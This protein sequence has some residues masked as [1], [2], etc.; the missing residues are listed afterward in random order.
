VEEGA[1]RRSMRPC[2]RNS[3]KRFDELSGDDGWTFLPIH[4]P[5]TNYTCR[6]PF[7]ALAT[8]EFIREQIFNWTLYHRAARQAGIRRPQHRSGTRYEA[9]T[10]KCDHGHTRCPT[11]FIAVGQQGRGSTAFA[12]NAFFEAN[13]RSKGR[14]RSRTRKTCE[15]G[16]T[17]SAEPNLHQC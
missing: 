13:G 10:A 9:L 3:T 12:L 14:Q 1:L 4:N 15:F 16:S 11:N 17:L 7:K 2:R 6:A 8:G 5:G